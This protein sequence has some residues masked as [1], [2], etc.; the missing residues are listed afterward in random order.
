MNNET[1]IDQASGKR[2]H[3]EVEV[4][5][6][7][8]VSDPGLRNPIDSFPLEMRDTLRRRYLAKGPCQPVG[9]QF[10]Q[11]NKRRFLPNWFKRFAWI[12][13]S[14]SKDKAFCLYCY[15]FPNK[16]NNS[17]KGGGNAFTEVGYSNWKNG[18]QN[19]IA[20]EGGPESPLTF[21]RIKVEQYQNQ[22]ENIDFVFS[23][24]NVANDDEYRVRLTTVVRVARYLLGEGLAFR[25]HDE[26]LKS[27]HR[28]HFLELLNWFCKYNEEANK[29]MLSNAPKNNQLTS[30]TIQRHI[31]EACG[32]ET[33][34]VILNE[35]GDKFFSLLLDEARDSSMKEQMAVVLRFVNDV[36]EIVESFVG[37]VHVIETSTQCLKNVVDEF[38]AI[39]GLSLSRLRGQGYDG[40]SNMRGELNGLKA[41]I[42]NENKHAHY[43]HCFA[44]QLQLVVVSAAE[45]N[46]D[47]SQFFDYIS[48]IV[49]MVGSSCKRNDALRQ[50]HH[51]KVVQKLQS[52]EISKG[53]GQ[54]QEISLARSGATCRDSHYKTLLRLFD[55]WDLLEE[56]LFAIQQDG[57]IRKNRGTARGLL[58]KMGVTDLLSKILQ[59]KDQNIAT[60]VRMVEALK[61]KLHA[62]RENGWENLLKETTKFCLKHKIKVPSMDEIIESHHITLVDGEPM[63]Y[64]HH[65]RVE[66]FA[67]VIDEVAE[68]LNNHFNEANTNLLKGV[69]SLDPSNNFACFDH[70]EILHLARLYSED[71]STAELAELND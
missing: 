62:Y 31:I 27:M 55:M 3:V 65:F 66:I 7:D 61:C 18:M 70:H 36:G 21:A 69:L 71:F 6:N 40:A 35:I 37:V 68:E 20:H 39:N 53:Q 24:K 34:K 8:I 11:T 59:A 19:F 56:V 17:N 29:V 10:P 43:I 25:G 63:T 58:D 32:K 9:H 12:E 52:G 28:G 1:P 54:N 26:S 50:A 57:E 23:S 16:G 51:D 49:N 48:M 22:R 46:H 4:S 5:D 60:A 42:L 15:L 33:R 38:F 14:V 13:Y 2:P 41:L 47:M 67:T 44:H 30:S 45:E 64:I